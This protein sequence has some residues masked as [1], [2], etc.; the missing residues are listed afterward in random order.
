MRKKTQLRLLYPAKLS[1]GMQ[2][3]TQFI[4][5]KNWEKALLSDSVYKIIKESSI[6]WR[7]MYPDGNLNPQE[8]RNKT[9]P[10]TGKEDYV[11]VKEH[12]YEY[13]FSFFS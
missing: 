1:F 8:K 2:M 5:K 7:Q 13:F 9:K 10:C 4:V 6:R 3:K 12:F 11:I